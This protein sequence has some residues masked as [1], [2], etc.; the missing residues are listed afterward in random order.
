[1][2][3]RCVGVGAALGDRID[4]IACKVE[5]REQSC[6][7]DATHTSG[8]SD[9]LPT[10]WHIMSQTDTAVKIGRLDEPYVNALQVGI[11]LDECKIEKCDEA[12]DQL[13]DLH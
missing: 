6:R 11:R 2:S 12:G 10:S 3:D 13:V 1:M 9:F 7:A 8:L 4:L 5:G